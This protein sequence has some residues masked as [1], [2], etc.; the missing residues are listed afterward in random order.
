MLLYFSSQ[1]ANNEDQKMAIANYVLL[2]RNKGP[3]RSQ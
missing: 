1:G 2:L 3:P